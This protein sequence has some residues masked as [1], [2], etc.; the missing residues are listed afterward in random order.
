MF[1]Y[2]KCYITCKNIISNSNQCLYF[3]HVSL[4]K[5]RGNHTTV[6]LSPCPLQSPQP[7]C[8]R[9]NA[10][11]SSRNIR[12]VVPRGTF[13]GP[14]LSSLVSEYQGPLSAQ[15]WKMAPTSWSWKCHLIRQC[16]LEMLI[17]FILCV[18]LVV[19]G[20]GKSLSQPSLCGVRR[21]FC[22]LLEALRDNLNDDS[23]RDCTWGKIQ[24]DKEIKFSFWRL[25]VRFLCV[26]CCLPHYYL[27]AVK[28]E[29]SKLLTECHMFIA[30]NVMSIWFLI[31]TLS[32]NS[33]SFFFFFFLNSYHYSS[34][35]F[36]D[37]RRQKC[38]SRIGIKR[39]KP[40]WWLL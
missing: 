31:E 9:H 22:L 5:L 21:C 34:W 19:K 13:T 14:A 28:I 27:C 26:T 37:T 12:K 16:C 3:R 10:N 20:L 17:C 33:W 40:K 35:Q 15:A 4:S 29:I 38:L 18:S 6:P 23:K 11:R 32:Y 7:L 1:E 24:N 25:D 2:R 8:P 39:F 30:M 36:Y